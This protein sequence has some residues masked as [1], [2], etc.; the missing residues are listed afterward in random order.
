MSWREFWNGHTT[1]YV[2][3]RHREIHYERIAQDIVSVLP[4]H[5][6][7]VLDFGCGE[8]LSAHLIARRCGSL[9][10]CDG[11]ETVREKLRA[12]TRHLDNSRVVTPE[13]VEAMPDA[14]FDLIV[15]NSVIQYFSRPELERWLCTWQRVLAPT[16]QLVIGDIV[17]RSVGPLVDAAALLKFAHNNGFLFAAA[18]GLVRTALSDYRRKRTQLGLLQ[19]EEH[20]IVDLARRAGLVAARSKRNLGHNPSRLTIVAKRFGEASRPQP[21][22]VFEPAR[23]V[24]MLEPATT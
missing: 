24:D 18:H 8:A 10:L 3:E 12:R 14:S 16:G 19:L 6:A 2:N 7:R 1:I 22:S 15:A 13:A 20:E 21:A 17:P 4:G 11:A 5:D 9:F 23:G